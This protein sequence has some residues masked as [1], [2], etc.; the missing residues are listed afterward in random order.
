LFGAADAGA[1]GAGDE[2]MADGEEGAREELELMDED[3]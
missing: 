3:G 2:E 1:F